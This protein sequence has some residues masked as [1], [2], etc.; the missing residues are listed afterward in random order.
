MSESVSL[1]YEVGNFLCEVW[2]VVFSVAFWNVSFVCVLYDAVE[3]GDVSVNVVNG[4][5]VQC[6]EVLFCFFNEFCPVC[7]FVVFVC[8]V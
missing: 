7:F 8:V 6:A 3:F 4:C 1:F 2:V 5:V